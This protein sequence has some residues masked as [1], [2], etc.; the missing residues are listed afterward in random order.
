MRPQTA[1]LAARPPFVLSMPWHHRRLVD[2]LAQLRRGSLTVQIAAHKPFTLHGVE[3][4]PDASIKIDRPGALMRRLF[5]RGDLGFGEGFIAEDWDSP[6]LARLLEVLA[7][8]LDAYAGTED[9]HLLSQ[10]RIRLQHWANRNTRSGSRR[11]IAAH[12]DLGNDFYAQWLDTSM[13]YS[14]ALFDQGI[15]LEEAQ[16]RKYARMLDELAAN[17]GDHILEIGCG[18]GGFAEYAARQGMCVTGLTLS[19]EQLEYARQRIQDAGLSELVEFK[20]CDYRDSQVV[21]D[22]VVSIEMFEAV[23][24]EYW[25]GYFDVVQRSLRPGGRASLQV[26]TIDETKFERYVANPGGFIQTYIFPGGMLPTKTHLDELGAGAGLTRLDMMPFGIDYADTL[27]QWHERF[28]RC[29]EWLGN[30]GYDQRFRR[31][32]QYYLTF[33]EAGFRA[34]HIDVVQCTFAKP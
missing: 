3:D 14:S 25:S 16:Q 12:Y 21:A 2:H 6:D 13:T 1:T 5:W 27:A 22:H 29:T 8:N 28:N 26:I 4:G 20:L 33:C 31:M 17:P 32:W 34:Q 9:R 15:A 30:H 18:W 10:T 19:V 23:G 11:N 24:R 7:L